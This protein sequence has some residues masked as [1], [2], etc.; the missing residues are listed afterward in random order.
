MENKQ[1]HSDHEILSHHRKEEC[2]L[3]KLSSTKE[4][5]GQGDES[6]F[7]HYVLSDAV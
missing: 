7:L 3:T 4:L 1:H 2:S 5:M 6:M